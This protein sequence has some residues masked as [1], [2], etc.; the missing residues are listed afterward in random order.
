MSHR[1][2]ADSIQLSFGQRR[3]LSD[4]YLRCDTG[5]ITALLG[6]N[7]QGKTCLMN[8]I[9]GSM[10]AENRSV[11]FDGIFTEYPFKRP[12]LLC[13]LPQ[14]S[15]I[16]KRFRLKTVFRDYRLSF[17]DFLTA[18][19]EFRNRENEKIGNL[20]GG[21][22]RLVEVYLIIKLPSQFVMLDEPF[23]HIMPLHVETLKDILIIEKERKGFLMSDHMYHQVTAVSD[24]IYLLKDGK[25]HLVRSLTDLEVLGYLRSSPT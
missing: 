16:P 25:T 18:F 1:M 13:Y 8:V 24:S 15:F 17:Q 5:K 6:R 22:I 4:I 9:Y 19:P 14:F 10:R 7:G 2:E 12:D 3:I 23:S 21:Q 20:S 11:R